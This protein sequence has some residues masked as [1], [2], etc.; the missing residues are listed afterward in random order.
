MNTQPPA[1]PRRTRTGA[2]TAPQPPK[3]EYIYHWNRIT[4]ALAALVLLVGLAGFAIHAWLLPPTAEPGDAGFETADT[5]AAH[6]EIAP[7]S[8]ETDAPG[9]HPEIAPE[10]G[11]RDVSEPTPAPVEPEVMASPDAADLPEPVEP[12]STP[13]PDAADLPGPVEQE[14][15]PAPDAADLP[16]PLEPEVMPAPDAADLPG[17]FE[18]ESMPAPDAATA[19][20]TAAA[21]EQDIRAR[22]EAQE[23]AEGDFSRVFLP[24]GTRVNL[25]AAPRLSSPVLR[26]LDSGAELWLVETAD[27]FYRVRS[28]EGIVGWVSRD[29][30]SLTPYAT[31]AR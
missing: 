5:P 1:G 20:D 12:E 6:P 19:P 13:A 29:F 31:P 11:E 16:G 3:T 4:G 2:R 25:R 30:S 10:S 23:A 8:R 17:P 21:F 9:P 18:Q 27:H 7:E 24:P 22:S 14:S 26:I 15:M 28:A